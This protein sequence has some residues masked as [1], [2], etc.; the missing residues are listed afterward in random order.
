VAPTPTHHL[1]IDMKIWRLDKEHMSTVPQ[2]QDIDIDAHKRDQQ[3]LMS[4]KYIR[5]YGVA[6][7]CG[8]H[9]GYCTQQY[10]QRFEQVIAVEP[11]DTFHECWHL[12]CKS[13]T[14]C[15]LLPY[16]LGDCEGKMQRDNAFAQVLEVNPLG[17]LPMHTVDSMALPQLDFIKIDVDGSEARLLQGARDTLTRLKPVIQIELK[18]N[19][20]LEVRDQAIQTLTE[21]GYRKRDK[22]NNDW[23]YTI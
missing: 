13:F 12:N 17:D 6:M 23:I 19:R 5:R 15:E 18:S 7:D 3:W 9:I 21:L 1:N 10:A 20:R 4:Q 2:L 8:A 11:N 14:N 22:T 16:A